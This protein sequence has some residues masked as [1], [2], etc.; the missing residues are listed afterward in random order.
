LQQGKDLEAASSHYSMEGI[1]ELGSDNEEFGSDQGGGGGGGCDE[2][3]KRTESRELRFAGG[4]V[5]GGKG[6]RKS[7]KYPPAHA[8]IIKVLRKDDELSEVSDV[9][10]SSSPNEE[11]LSS[12]GSH[13]QTHS[14]KQLKYLEKSSRA[15]TAQSR[16]TKAVGVCQTC[17]KVYSRIHL[18]LLRTSP[19][20]QVAQ[21][22][23]DSASLQCRSGR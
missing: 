17:M 3:V 21:E 9:S 7:H 1:I 18:C 8:T 6:A 11:R 16:L 22:I 23:V 19:D 13:A 20:S 12:M 10:V 15:F 5:H 14:V 4:P 2:Q